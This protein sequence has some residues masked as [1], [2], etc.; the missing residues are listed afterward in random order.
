MGVRK[1]KRWY[2]REGKSKKKEWEGTDTKKKMGEKGERNKER[3][4]NVVQM[5]VR[6]QIHIGRNV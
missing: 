5:H 1:K 3:G 4:K 2:E 6:H